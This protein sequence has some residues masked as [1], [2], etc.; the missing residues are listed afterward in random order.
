MIMKQKVQISQDTL[1]QFLKDRNLIVS[2]IGKK[3]GI[4]NGLLV[5]CFHHNLNRLGKPLSFSVA[6]I[7]R[8][9]TA[10]WQ[11]AEELRGCLLTFGSEQTF[12]NQRGTTYDP[13]LVDGFKRIGEY[14]K[15][16]GLTER[17][18]GWNKAKC[19]GTLNVKSS[20]MYGRISQSDSDRINA[21]LLAVAGVLSSYEVVAD[22]RSDSDC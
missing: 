6:N 9:N 1:Y 3:T 16:R 22:G 19:E 10:I 12:T 18:L 5:G 11:I 20:P 8:I 2:L 14:L 7:E 13:A 4:G 15:L 21:E 17:I